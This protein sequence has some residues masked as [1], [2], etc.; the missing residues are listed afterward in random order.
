MREIVFI[1]I[2]T[3]F[4]FIMPQGKLY[5]KGAKEL[6]PDFR[7]LT[8]LAL[9]NDILIISSVDTH[10]KND[11]EFK[12]FPS[13][14]VKGSPG[15]KKI[16]ETLLKRHILLPGKILNRGELFSRIKSYKQ[17]IVEKDNVDTFM[18]LNIL[19]ILKPFK[20]AFV[21]GLALDYCVKAAVLD[22]LKAG[23]K[24]NLV[25]DAT[26]AIDHKGGK[27]LLAQFKKS[28]VQLIKTKD[29]L[30]EIKKYERSAPT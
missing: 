6:I 15:Q 3:Q 18:D 8:Q 10:L 4:D 28:S 22:L 9:K 26:R 16:P 12:Q 19:R 23:L 29:V 17:L 14:C 30:S 20:I 1:D 11:P 27:L 24:I 13:H 21:Y 7:L 25:V 2:D 5:V